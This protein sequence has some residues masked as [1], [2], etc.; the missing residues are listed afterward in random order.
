MLAPL[1]A[2]NY[3]EGRGKGVAI[4]NEFDKSSIPRFAFHMFFKQQAH[5]VPRGSACLGWDNLRVVPKASHSPNDS[6]T[7]LLCPTPSPFTLEHSLSATTCVQR[8]RCTVCAAGRDE[9]AW[10]SMRRQS[11][12]SVPAPGLQRPASG[13]GKRWRAAW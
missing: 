4:Y 8:V 11:L 12:R 5:L 9:G 10:Q 13:G 7:T 6:R 1:P 2:Q 3:G